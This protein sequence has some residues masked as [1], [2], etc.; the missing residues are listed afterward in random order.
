[1]SFWKIKMFDKD[2]YA[3]RRKKIET[4]RAK[5]L[6]RL[7]NASFDFTNAIAEIN[8]EMNELN[9]R[10]KESQSGGKEQAKKD[11]MEQASDIVKKKKA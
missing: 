3:D 11:V 6:Q 4:K 5:I 1:M 7:V 8:D 2:Y 10:E 9:L